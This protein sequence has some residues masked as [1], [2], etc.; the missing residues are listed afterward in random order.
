MDKHDYII[1]NFIKYVGQSVEEAHN[2]NA[3]VDLL[4]HPNDVH[5]LYVA[6]KAKDLII[7]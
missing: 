3:G 6:F 7:H 5:E 1:M 2:K 4:I